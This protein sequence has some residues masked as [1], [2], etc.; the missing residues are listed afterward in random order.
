[1]S[2]AARHLDPAAEPEPRPVLLDLP[3]D[4]NN[5]ERRAFIHGDYKLLVFGRDYRIELYNIIKD[6]G[7]QKNLRKLEPE[8]YA[9][10]KALYQK[11]WGAVPKVKP[12]GGNKLMGG[13]RATGPVE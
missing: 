13:G 2:D 9:E 10:M 5:D 3:P 6:P 8:K 12:F 11:V 1:M 4:S 7:E